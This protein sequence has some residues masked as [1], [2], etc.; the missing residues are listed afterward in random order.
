[1]TRARAAEYR[2]LAQE[3]FELARAV[4]TEEARASLVAM[5]E[6]WL[7]LAEEQDQSPDFTV[8]PSHAEQPTMQQQQ[9]V[10]PK[11]DGKKD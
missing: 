1:M 7:R 4:S 2:R 6:I 5:A 9:Q 10:Q 8:P 3:C 11:D